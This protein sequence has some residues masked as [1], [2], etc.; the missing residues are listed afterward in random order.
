VPAQD[1]RALGVHLATGRLVCQLPLA[2]RRHP[3]NLC[4]RSRGARFGLEQGCRAPVEALPG[5]HQPAARA[6]D[7][8]LRTPV[9][10]RDEHGKVTDQ[11][12][13]ALI[14]IVS[15]AIALIRQPVTLIRQPVAL[16]GHPV[17]LI[18]HPVVLIGQPVALVSQP[19]TLVSQPV[20]L[21]RHPVVLIGHPV[22]FVS[23]MLAPVRSRG[24][25]LR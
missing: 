1:R 10:V 22:A 5:G 7:G 23:L 17:V 15:L 11:L 21:I 24:T 3:V 2:F 18:R 14:A 6:L 16:I 20:V 25:C 8:L 13:E 12:N 4:L 9:P 19:V